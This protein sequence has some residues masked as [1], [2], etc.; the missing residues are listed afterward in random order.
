MRPLNYQM[1]STKSG[2]TDHFAEDDHHAL[3]IVRS[4]MSFADQGRQA[5]ASSSV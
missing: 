3:Q 5:T 2:V 4:I 1:H